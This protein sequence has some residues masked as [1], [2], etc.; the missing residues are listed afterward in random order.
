MHH[1]ELTLGHTAYWSRQSLIC[2]WF[3]GFAT[4]GCGNDGEDCTLV[5]ASLINGASS[6]DISLIPPHEFSVTSGFGYYDGCDGVGAD[7]KHV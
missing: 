6:A 2:T 7:T 1:N 5:E 4:G 3:C